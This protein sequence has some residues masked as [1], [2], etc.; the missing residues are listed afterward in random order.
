MGT[1]ERWEANFGGDGQDQSVTVLCYSDG[2]DLDNFMLLGAP[3]VYTNDQVQTAQNSAGLITYSTADKGGGFNF[4]GQTFTVGAGVTNLGGIYLLLN[5]AANVTVQ[6]FATPTSTTPLASTSVNVATSGA[7]Q[8]LFGLANHIIVT[9]GTQYFFTVSCDA[10]QSIYVYYQNSDVYA[11]GQMYNANFGG[12]S[13]GGS[14]GVMTGNDLYFITASSNGQTIATF[15]SQ[16][17]STGILAG[18][19]TDYRSR[20]GNITYNGSSVVATGLSLTYQFN[21]NTIYEGIQAMLSVSPFG[22]YYYVDLATDILYF[23]PV[24]TTPDVLLTKGKHINR[25]TII[26]TIENIY[27]LAFF[28]GG[29]PTGTTT[30]LYSNYINSTSIALFGPKLE[31]LSDNRVVDQGTADAIGTSA[32]QESGVEQYQSTVTV[33]DKTMDISLLKPGMIVGFR[34]FGTFADTIT[35]QIVRIDYAP[36]FATLTLGVVPP[37]LNVALEAVTRGLIAQETIANPP[38]PS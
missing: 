33:L 25:L 10:N 13:G 6:I 3:F 18:F 36:E 29:L 2:S 31:R 11:G 17:P 38:T 8:I 15:T 14:Y 34:G 20:G 28:S 30:N 7:Q 24:S 9:A 12:G 5:G 19:M 22:F 21:T 23:K 4:Y 16:D 37:E 26:A 27:N 32:V 35:S 1:M